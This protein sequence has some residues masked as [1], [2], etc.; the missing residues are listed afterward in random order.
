MGDAEVE[1]RYDDGEIQREDWS[2]GT[3]GDAVFAANPRE[4]KQ[5]LLIADQ[6][7]IRAKS[8]GASQTLVFD[9][10]NLENQIM[11]LDEAMKSQG[12]YHNR[13]Q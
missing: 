10:S 11:P 13:S 2:L 7:V 3:S 1:M 8:S 4:I 12:R 5:R 6:F 9:V